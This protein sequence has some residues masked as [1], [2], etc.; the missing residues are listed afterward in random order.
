[1][2]VPAV[3]SR[4]Y[5]T[6]LLAR[7]L[8]AMPDRRGI[9]L[10]LR[11]YDRLF[12]YMLGVIK[13]TEDGLHPKHRITDL[14]AFF[15]NEVAPGDRVLDVGCAYGQIAGA[16]ASKAASVTGVDIRPGAVE[17]ARSEFTRP[18]LRFLVGD[19]ATLPLDNHFDVVVLSNVL[20][21]VRDRRAFLARC[22][23]LAPKLLVRVPAIDR[24]WL[25]P[26][27]QE[28]GLEWRLHPDHEIE[29]TEATLAGELEQA[30]FRIVRCRSRYG[31]LHCVAVRA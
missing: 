14:H 8:A 7:R 9:K 16:L 29:Y 19:F 10:L 23:A 26:Y 15:V 24:D 31:A 2:G 12:Y 25:V 27:R 1:M 22:R 18:N 4:R 5:W 3:L 11:L 17:R 13:L 20:E 6:T 30:G 28:L 21:H